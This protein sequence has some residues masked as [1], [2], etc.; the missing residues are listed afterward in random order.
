MEYLHISRPDI[1]K[2]EKQLMTARKAKKIKRVLKKTKSKLYKISQKPKI[3]YTLRNATKSNTFEYNSCSK[4][5]YTFGS[6]SF[7][8]KSF[9]TD[10]LKTIH[11]LIVLLG[12]FLI[13]FYKSR[14]LFNYYFSKNFQRPPPVILSI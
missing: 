3:Y 14:I 13:N 11:I 7:N 6:G 1:K 8:F 4:I 10:D 12:I 5:V 9:V 2:K